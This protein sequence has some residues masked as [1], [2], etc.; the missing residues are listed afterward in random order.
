[1]ENQEKDA[2]ST[3]RL[4]RE[5][6]RLRKEW[7]LGSGS[8]T[9]EDAPTRVLAFRNGQLRCWVNTSILPVNLPP[10]SQVI[11]SSTGHLESSDAVNSF[12]GNSAYSGPSPVLEPNVTMWF[13]WGEK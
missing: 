2:D 11:L 3:L 8:L 5:S 6:L 1:M 9:W 12:A 13:T 10:G 7:Q 4:Y